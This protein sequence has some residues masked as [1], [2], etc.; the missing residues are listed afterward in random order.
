[1]L[2]YMLTAVLYYQRNATKSTGFN[3]ISKKEEEEIE[4]PPYVYDIIADNK[5]HYEYMLRYKINI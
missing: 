1:M 2:Q 4:Y 3:Q 5:P